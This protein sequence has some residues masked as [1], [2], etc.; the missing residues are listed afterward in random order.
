MGSAATA[1][2]ASTPTS[3]RLGKA[4]RR[5]F[6]PEPTRWTRGIPTRNCETIRLNS[7]ISIASRTR[8]LLLGQFCI[9]QGEGPAPPGGHP[10][11]KRN[12]ILLG[13]S[14]DGFHWHRPD[15]RP[16]MGCNS[17]DPKAWNWG[18]VQSV[19]GGCLIVGD[20]LYFYCSGWSKAQ[21]ARDRLPVLSTGLATLRRD[22]F[23]SMDANDAGGTL[24]TRPVSFQGKHLFVNVDSGKGGELRVEILDK[25]GKVIQPFTQEACV[26]LTGRQDLAPSQVERRGRTVEA[27]R[28][29]RKVQIPF[30]ER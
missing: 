26:P 6:G 15:R 3:W 17:D 14:R 13:F 19:G 20:K 10:N 5:C 18:N 12:E 21:D 4:H 9:W 25:E 7:T 28:P 24:T 29:A 8:V 2:I 16:F 1:V 22:G 11:P 27:G 30:E 23:A